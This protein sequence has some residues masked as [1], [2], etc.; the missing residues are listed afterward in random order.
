MQEIVR[1]AEHTSDVDRGV[2]EGGGA[3]ERPRGS[4]VLPIHQWRPR[5]RIYRPARTPTRSGWAKTR[6]WVVEFEPLSPAAP[7]PLMEMNWLP[8][9]LA[10]RAAAVSLEGESDC[11]RS[12][13]GLELHRFRAAGAT[14][15]TQ[16][17]RRQRPCTPARRTCAALG[18][19]GTRIARPRR[20][21]VRGVVSGERLAGVD[22][23]DGDRAARRAPGAGT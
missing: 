23:R 6:R 19:G 20:G 21:S 18:A 4:A 22:T 13:A 7:D 1:L 12:K 5:V 10:T 9:H 16:E 14:A 11:L 17:L 15:A 2:R 3:L 8:R